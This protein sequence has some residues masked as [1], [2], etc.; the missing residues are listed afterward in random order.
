MAIRKNIFRK[1]TS[2]VNI[3]QFLI[4]LNIFKLYMSKVISG[5]KYG[6]D[7]DGVLHKSVGIPTIHGF[8]ETHPNKIFESPNIFIIQRIN[9]IIES[10]GKIEIISSTSNQK[11]IFEFLEKISSGEINIPGI[12]K[13]NFNPRRPIT[14]LFKDDGDLAIKSEEDIKSKKY[15]EDYNIDYNDNIKINTNTR[16][17]DKTD[18]VYNS[19]VIEYYDDSTIVLLKIIWKIMNELDKGKFRS[20]IL[21]NVI[22]VL[23]K[24]IFIDQNNFIESLNM[25]FTKW[26]IK[27]LS[28]EMNY[29]NA[30]GK[31]I[32]QI[33][34]K[35]NKIINPRALILKNADDI[36]IN[37]L[38]LHINIS[39]IDIKDKYIKYIYY[40]IK[41]DTFAVKIRTLLKDEDA[42]LIYFS[43][44]KNNPNY[45]MLSVNG[46]SVSGKSI[47]SNLIADEIKKLA[48]THIDRVLGIT[49]SNREF[50]KTDGKK[51]YYLHG[52]DINLYDYEHKEYG[53]SYCNMLTCKTNLDDYNLSKI[54]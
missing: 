42:I 6:F 32:P 35:G 36:I 18:I 34:K 49:T 39:I 2:Y 44:Y 7:F 9:E 43:F 31:H 47:I 8:P 46:W 52:T 28:D 51:Y 13:I 1:V 10:G 12:N 25:A 50:K 53:I 29:I 21:F 40:H 19:Q 14:G 4:Y 54:F 5:E 30:G 41:I 20:I 23:D 3:F 15:N 33:D 37:E 27:L 11:G 22:H 17:N 38:K 24:Y 26:N 48:E 16:R 45:H